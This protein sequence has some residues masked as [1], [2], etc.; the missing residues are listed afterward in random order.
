MGRLPVMLVLLMAAVLPLG[1]CEATVLGENKHGIWFR[2][3]FIGSGHTQSQALRHCAQF[4]KTANYV[5]T[6]DPGQG[7]TLPVVAYNCE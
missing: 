2:E 5:G 7:M 6:L 4:G 1:G 3:P